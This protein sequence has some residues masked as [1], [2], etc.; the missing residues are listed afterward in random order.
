MHV[1]GVLI[2]PVQL[3]KSLF[4]TLLLVVFFGRMVAAENFEDQTIRVGIY[5]NEPKIFTTESGEPAGIF[6]DVIENI[7]AREGWRLRYI[8]GTWAEGLE[9]LAKG[10][11][12]IMPDV[13][14]SIDRKK[15]FSFH[16]VP[17]LSSWSQVYA[18]KGA[19]IAS[20]LDL[21]GKNVLVLEDSVQQERFARL[22]ESFGLDITLTTMPDYQTMF[23]AVTR[24][25]ADALITNRFY[26][27]MHAKDGGL[28][29]TAVMFDPSDLFFAAP[30]DTH[31]DILQV[32]DRHLLPLK[33]DTHSIYYTSLQRWT[34]DKVELTLPFWLKMLGLSGLGL[35]ILSLFGSMIMKHQVDAATRELRQIN[36]EMEQ[37]IAERTAELATAMEKALAADRLKSTFLAT[38]SHEL[39]TP[40]N[41]IIG[42]TGIM[43]QGLTGT[44]NEEQQKQM[45]MVQKSS[46]HL[47]AL[48]NDVLDISKIEAGQLLLARDSFALGAS[49][50]KIV[51]MV[52]PLAEQKGIELSMDIAPDVGTIDTDQR[53]LE[54]VLVNLLNNGV[55]FTEEGYV[56]IS[57]RNEKD[58]SIITVSDSGIGMQPDEVAGIFQPFHQIDTG[59]ARKLEGTGLGLSI[60]KKII[61]LM[62]GSIE[63]TSTWTK[64]S[65]FTLRIPRQTGVVS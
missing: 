4:C 55:K 40:L 43:L 16:E 21:D 59:L 22:A 46:R 35:L 15:R 19:K 11:I 31:T 38:M 49:I 39:R 3:I 37:R 44:L 45:G 41:S 33:K 48:I 56:R 20:I 53:R 64:G 10:Q 30:L 5:E 62:H 32:L 34:A 7:A 8:H 12:D 2:L 9:R 54:Q 63:V 25:E 57:C 29:N 65:T 58:S 47:L 26:G 51:K 6:V 13:A 23:A 17:V 50:E 60:S 52:L 18:R 61:D 14:R 1:K 24:G 28:E 42:F 36:Q 27:L